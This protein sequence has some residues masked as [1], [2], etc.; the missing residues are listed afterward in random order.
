MTQFTRLPEYFAIVRSNTYSGPS[1]Q[2]LHSSWVSD[3]TRGLADHFNVVDDNTEN[4]A[5]VL[6]L[7]ERR[8]HLHDRHIYSARCKHPNTSHILETYFWFLPFELMSHR[9]GIP[10]L[11]FHTRAWIPRAEERVQVSLSFPMDNFILVAE[12]IQREML[13]EIR[14]L[15]DDD[16]QFMSRFRNNTF[17]WFSSRNISSG[18]DDYDDRLGPGNF[19]GAGGY[20]RRR[21]RTPSPVPVP[22]IV[23]SVRIVE[24]PV[25]RVVVQTRTAP[26]P[27]AI[28]DIILAGARTGTDSCPIASIPFKDCTQICVTSCFH[29]FETASLNRWREDHTTCPVCR[30][31]I[32]NVVCETTTDGVPRV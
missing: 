11:E 26:L 28:G 32:E 12:N 29:I 24:V 3:R 8:N 30:A 27:K 1:F 18:P 21:P 19:V 15:E 2:V 25:E 10:V 9:V 14:R 20:N 31:R 16:S 23:E 4:N 6:H 13:H 22:R 17:S 7:E 5:Y